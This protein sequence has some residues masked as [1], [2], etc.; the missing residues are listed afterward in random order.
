MTAER[1]HL[2]VVQPSPAGP[3]DQALMRL[4]CAGERRALEAVAQRHLHEVVSFCA[5]FLSDA[6]AGEEVAQ[7]VFIG[8]W[9]QRARYDERQKFREYLYTLAINRCRNRDRWWRR[10][11]ARTAALKELLRSGPDTELGRRGP[12]IRRRVLTLCLGC[13]WG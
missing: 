2:Y 12:F 9:E 8:L 5:R 4:V 3:D 11:T 7:E 6:A 13:R 1:P 10:L